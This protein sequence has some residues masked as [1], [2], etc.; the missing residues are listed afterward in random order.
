M[1]EFS[2]LISSGFREA[3]DMIGVDVTCNGVTRKTISTPL[4]TAQ[5]L[6]EAGYL[7]GIDVVIELL[8]TDFTAMSI[9]DRSEITINGSTVCVLG[10]DDDPAEP[11]VKLMCKHA[12]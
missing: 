7:P 2:D 3:R 5:Q 6:Q 8:R 4:Q 9:E 10:I 12:R 11:C 1:S